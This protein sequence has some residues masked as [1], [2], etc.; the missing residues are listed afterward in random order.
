VALR[1]TAQETGIDILSLD[2]SKLERLAASGLRMVG[3]PTIAAC[4]CTDASAIVDMSAS[5]DS[6]PGPPLA[7]AARHD[8][9]R[10]PATRIRSL[11]ALYGEPAGAK[12]VRCWGC[13]WRRQGGKRLDQNSLH[14]LQE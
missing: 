10:F 2:R 13:H 11:S 9:I 1:S 12:T 5:E 4:I 6:E 14:I 8:I 3:P 7:I